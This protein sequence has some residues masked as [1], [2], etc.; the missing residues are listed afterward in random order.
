M[1][2]PSSS[3]PDHCHICGKPACQGDCP[4][5]P[6]RPLSQCDRGYFLA[7]VVESGEGFIRYGWVCAECYT[8]PNK[9]KETIKSCA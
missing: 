6:K 2:V 1:A 3:R 8:Q 4:K 5:C 9:R 7:V